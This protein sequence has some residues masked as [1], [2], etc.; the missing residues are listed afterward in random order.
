MAKK[1][2]TV[3]PSGEAKV[4]DMVKETRQHVTVYD[5]FGDFLEKFEDIKGYSVNGPYFVVQMKD[6]TQHV[7]VTANIRKITINSTKD[8]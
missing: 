2:L 6:D 4:L 8:E 3:V 1:E 5:S 7:F